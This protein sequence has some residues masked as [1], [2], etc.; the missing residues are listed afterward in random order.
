MSNN[1]L[2]LIAHKLFFGVFA[3]IVKCMSFLSLCFL[4]FFEDDNKIESTASPHFLRISFWSTNDNVRLFI[5]FLY[6]L[7]KNVQLSQ[8]V[9]LYDFAMNTVGVCTNCDVDVGIQT[10]GMIPYSLPIEN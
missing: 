4:Y 9:L 7:L 2:E 10:H 6:I 1:Q 8:M 3:L 5:Y